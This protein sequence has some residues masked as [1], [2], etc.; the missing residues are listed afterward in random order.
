MLKPNVNTYGGA[1]FATHDMP[2]AICRDMPA[3]LD[4]STGVMQPCWGCQKNGWRLVRATG[5]ITKHILKSLD[6]KQRR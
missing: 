4:L 2:C 3:V 5:N 6:E 1:P